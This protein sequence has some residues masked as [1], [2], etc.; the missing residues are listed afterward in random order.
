MLYCN[1]AVPIVAK[2]RNA[3]HGNRVL[4][5]HQT[6]GCLRPGQVQLHVFSWMRAERMQPLLA[7]TGST[8]LH[9]ARFHDIPLDLVLPNQHSALK[10]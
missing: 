6:F 10:N 5:S 8:Q 2:S 1:A 3:S 4:G 7:C 9:R